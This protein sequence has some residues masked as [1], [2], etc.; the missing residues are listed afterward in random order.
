MIKILHLS[1]VH[2]DS[3]FRNLTYS[4]SVERRKKLR[5]VFSNALDFAKNNEVSVILIAGDLFDSEFYTENTVSFLCDAFNSMPWCRFIISPGNHDPYKYGS[6]YTKNRFPENVFVFDSEKMSGFRFPEL[7]LTVYGYAFTS[8]TYTKRPLE[9]FSA[10]TCGFNVLCAHADTA[11]A[12]TYAPISASEL[13]ASGLDY[14]AL[15]HIHTEKEILSAGNTTY[16]YACVA[17]HDFWEYGEKGAVLVSL[18]IENGIKTVKTEKI[19]FCPWIYQTLKINLS[20]INDKD[21]LF[22]YLLKQISEELKIPGKSI[23]PEKLKKSGGNAVDELDK[24][25]KMQI[26]EIEYITKIILTGEVDFEIEVEHLLSRLKE[27]GVLSIENKTGLSISS[28]GLE[29]DFSIKGEFYRSLKPYLL[30][31]NEQERQRAE[32]ALKIGLAALDRR[33]ISDII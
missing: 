30:S 19:N 23:I 32:K 31:E 12:V 20:G 26:S 29:E 18:D 6:P 10:E 33:D 24:Y 14:A 16:A 8:K 4:E 22:G 9:N 27:Y 28:L 15:G 13:E 2:L 5:E 17:G 25:G 3:P 11:G 21:E 1:D 7:D